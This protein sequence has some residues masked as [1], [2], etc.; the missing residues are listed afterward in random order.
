MEVDVEDVLLAV[1]PRLLVEAGDVNFLE[2]ALA[3]ERR[4]DRL[5][6]GDRPDDAVDGR[7]LLLDVELLDVVGRRLGVVLRELDHHVEGIDVR[8]IEVVVR[9][10]RSAGRGA[11]GPGHALAVSSRQRRTSFVT[12]SSAASSVVTSLFDA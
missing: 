6:F 12:V 7:V 5:P 1:G 10:R 11:P 9:A 8:G 3:L 2:A 4:L